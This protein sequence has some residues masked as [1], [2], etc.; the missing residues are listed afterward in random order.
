MK[1]K[2]I[3][4]YKGFDRNLKCRGWQYRVGETSTFNGKIKVGVSGLHFYESSTNVFEIY[5]PNGLGRYAET[6]SKGRT[7]YD[8]SYGAYCTDKLEVVEELSIE[9]MYK[10]RCKAPRIAKLE[11]ENV[12]VGGSLEALTERS[13]DYSV[14]ISAFGKS[15]SLTTGYASTAITCD[16]YSYAKSMGGYSTSI[17]LRR[18]SLAEANGN[19]SIA[20]AAKEETSAKVT[21]RGSIALSQYALSKVYVSAG[22][23][24]ILLG[25]NDVEFVGELGAVVVVLLMDRKREN[26]TG[27]K[28]F[29]VDGEIILPNHIYT[30][31][32]GMPSDR[33]IFRQDYGK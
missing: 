14:C 1:R 10:R 15:M 11:P 26:Y 28:T 5:P 6:N 13:S 23:V 32:D 25:L 3:K 2:E 27:A 4:G 30:F 16:L 20:V 19:R 8:N 22:S 12:Y 33:G 24:G 7:L 31:E 18:Y 29:V 17:A 21:E 9:E